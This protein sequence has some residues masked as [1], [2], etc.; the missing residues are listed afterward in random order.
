MA[1]EYGPLILGGNVFGWTVDPRDSF[2]L[3]DAFVD[4]GGTSIDTADVYPA[5]ADGRDGGESEEIIGSWMAERGNR[6]KL[7][8]ATKVGK[9]SEQP[10][11][12]P[13]NIRSAVERSLRRLQT[14]Y[15]DIYYAHEDDESVE[16]K[17]YVEAFDALVK[18]GKV[19]QI[20]ASNFEPHRLSAAVKLAK[21]NG[22][23][24]FTVS[25]DHWNLVERDIEK[26]LVPALDEHGLTELPYW[27]LA[28]GLL[29]GKYRRG[30]NVDSARAS[31]AGKYL[32]DNQN[33][34]LLNRL[35]EVA[36][37]H[38]T[39][40]A[41][42]SLAWLRAQDIVGAPIASARTR[43]QMSDLFDTVELA[44]EELAGLSAMTRP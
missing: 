39:S 9:W 22:Y 21:D 33:V 29:T 38:D 42:V 8:I 3:L 2:D 27:S 32:L 44:P 16:Q 28:S 37:A 40:V 25:Q 18:E 7:V 26:T 36:T 15:I 30:K 31:G 6:D 12:S 11:L 43:E 34:A 13:D 14:D 1:L 17:A 35:D 19:R 23:T 20:G 5:W 41:S 10:G 24:G 4:H